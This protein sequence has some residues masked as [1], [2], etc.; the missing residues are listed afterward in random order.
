MAK[1]E[2][3]LIHNYFGFQCEE[4]QLKKSLSK[5]FK[6]YVIFFIFDDATWRRK[7]IIVSSRALAILNL[8]FDMKTI[9]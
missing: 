6:R 4:D 5:T 2:N 3:R 9:Y 8:G 7:K 1:I